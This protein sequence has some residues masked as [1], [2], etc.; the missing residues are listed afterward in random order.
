MVSPGVFLS[1]GR[2]LVFWL[3]ADSRGSSGVDGSRHGPEDG[4]PF[5]QRHSRR[6][7]A[8]IPCRVQSACGGTN[9]SCMVPRESA[10]RHGVLKGLDHRCP[11]WRD[12]ASPAFASA[13][14]AAFGARDFPFRPEQRR[15][16]SFLGRRRPHRVGAGRVLSC[17]HEPIA[18]DNCASSPVRRRR[19]LLWRAR[20]RRRWGWP[21]PAH[22]PHRLFDGRISREDL[23]GT[24][25]RR[26]CGRRL[27][28]LIAPG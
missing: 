8:G 2:S 18:P 11:P 9:E 25:S 26:R 5:A 21:D 3:M 7:G 12:G 15:R 16:D 22:M 6:G 17:G 20:H 28:S 14:A 10:R 13:T 4:S 27:N 1:E 19:L 23:T 24:G